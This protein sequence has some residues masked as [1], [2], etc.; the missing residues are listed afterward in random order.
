[1]SMTQMMLG[2]AGG[3]G[4]L[5]TGALNSQQYV[6]GPAN[7]W[8]YNP[9]VS[10]PQGTL[11]PNTFVVGGVTLTVTRITDIVI[12]GSVF[13]S[14]LYITG[15]ASDPGFAF[16]YSAQWGA[17]PEFVYSRGSGGYFWDSATSQGQWTFSVTSTPNFGLSAGGTNNLILRG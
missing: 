11:S 3:V 15:F 14:V 7:S 12:S 8:G 4:A 1:M 13:Q 6:A 5:F 9:A 17:N 10:P 16:L 2:A